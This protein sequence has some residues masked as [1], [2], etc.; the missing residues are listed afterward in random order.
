[1]I[2]LKLTLGFVGVLLVTPWVVKS[3]EIFNSTIEVLN[4]IG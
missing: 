4:S 3:L 2:I 1:M